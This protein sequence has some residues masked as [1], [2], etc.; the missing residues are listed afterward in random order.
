MLLLK[1]LHVAYRSSL[2][3][4]MI[5]MMVCQYESQWLAAGSVILPSGRQIRR[6]YSW[7][8]TQ[9]LSSVI[10]PEGMHEVDSLSGLLSST[11]VLWCASQLLS[12]LI[13]PHGLPLGY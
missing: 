3:A 12:G 11:L 5:I 13:L 9:L 2:H 10:L 1:G 7:H 4:C 8:K 6:F